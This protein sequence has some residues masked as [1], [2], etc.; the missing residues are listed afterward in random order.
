[1]SL[2]AVAGCVLV[3]HAGVPSDRHALSAA[4]D[5]HVHQLVLLGVSRQGARRGWLSLRARTAR[6]RARPSTPR[7]H[8]TRQ[9]VGN[10]RLE[11]HGTAMFD[12]A[13][14]VYS[15]ISGSTALV[16]RLNERRLR[17]AARR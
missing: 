11:P 17:G 5:P 7:E 10:Q 16:S 9:G 14:V 2:Y 12:A 13:T 3:G 4:G 15:P 6:G 1:L 8:T